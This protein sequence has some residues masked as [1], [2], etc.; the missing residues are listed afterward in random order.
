[1]AMDAKTEAAR[2]LMIDQ[3]VRASAVLDPR[4]L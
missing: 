4:V 1:M 2:R 3:Q